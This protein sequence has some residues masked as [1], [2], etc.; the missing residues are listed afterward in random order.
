MAQSL[1]ML[2]VVIGFMVVLI[3]AFGIVWWFQNTTEIKLKDRQRPDPDKIPFLQRLT[4]SEKRQKISDPFLY[5]TLSSALSDHQQGETAYREGDYTQ[6]IVHFTRALGTLP[7]AAATYYYRGF[8]YL[9]TG[10]QAMAIA[11]FEQVLKV[12]DNPRWLVQAEEALRGLR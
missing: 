9:H 8:A 3:V 7:Y 12:S 1:H 2:P 6:A 5:D 11:D 10:E 4:R